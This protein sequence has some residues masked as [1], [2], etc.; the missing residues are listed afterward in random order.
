MKKIFLTIAL[1]LSTAFAT[2][3]TGQL[4]EQFVS[5]NGISFTVHNARQISSYQGAVQIID[6]DGNNS[7]TYL[8]D[9]TGSVYAQIKNTAA[10]KASY[11]KVYGA[12]TWVNVAA[13]RWVVCNNDKLTMGW[14]ASNSGDYAD[15]GCSVYNLIK[16]MSN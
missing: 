1:F 11:V 8:Q 10:F 12:E 15:P 13:A 5:S 16:A 6:R 3:G 4:T 14:L 2:A 9:A 7:Y